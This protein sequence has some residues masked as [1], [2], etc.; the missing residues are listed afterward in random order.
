MGRV[1][2][3]RGSADVA[4]IRALGQSWSHPL[5]VLYTAP[6]NLDVLRLGVSA[7]RRIGKAVVR[8]RVRRRVREAARR[9]LCEGAT[10][11]SALADGSGRSVSRGK[12][13]LFIAR[14][15]SGTAGWDALQRAVEDLLQRARLNSADGLVPKGA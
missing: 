7:S 13:F 15:P 14:A 2:R 8:N 9:I 6:N 3:L 11:E 4:R 5:L 10:T 12:D 1:D